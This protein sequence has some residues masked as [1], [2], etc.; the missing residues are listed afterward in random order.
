MVEMERCPP[1]MRGCVKWFDPG[2][3]FGFIVADDGGPDILLHV[4]ALRAF[5]QSTVCDGAMVSVRV[6]QTDRGLQAAEV[7]EIEPPL[8]SEAD[9]AGAPAEAEEYAQ[10]PLEPARVKWFDRVKGF[11]FGNV[12]GRAEDVFIHMEAL[13]RSGFADLQ[14]GEAVALRIVEGDRGRLAVMVAP[15]EMA[16]REPAPDSAAD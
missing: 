8:D 7:I 14:P 12:F 4:N 9:A 16:L 2:K 10:L 11:G 3:G 6:Q 1:Q 13:R 5:G 15:W